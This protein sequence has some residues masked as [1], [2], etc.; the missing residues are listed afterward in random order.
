MQGKQRKRSV[1]TLT[2]KGRQRK[3]APLV[4]RKKSYQVIITQKTLTFNAFTASVFTNRV[5]CNQADNVNNIN[6]NAFK[7]EE[8]KQVRE[9]TH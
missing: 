6:I 9:H 7:I 8:R 3:A 5:G 1:R 4:N 2:A